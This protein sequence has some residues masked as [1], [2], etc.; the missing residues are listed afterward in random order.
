MNIGEALPR[1]AQH[2]PKKLALHDGT[3]SVSHLDLHLR[4]NRLS[5]YLLQHGVRRSDPV[6]FSCGNRTENFEIF[7]ALAKIGAIAV[8]FDYHWS[9]DECRM[10]FEFIAPVAVIL[11]GRSETYHLSDFIQERFL[12]SR[13]ITIDWPDADWSRPY[14]EALG[15]ATPEDPPVK[16]DGKDNLL[17]MITSGTTGFPKACLVNHETYVMRSLNNAIANSVTSDDRALLT[18]PLHFNAG[19]GSMTGVLYMGGTVFIQE[20]FSEEQF[21]AT[22][23]DEKISYTTLV[24]T[25]CTRLL[26]YPDLERYS[27]SFLRYI[28]VTGGQLSAKQSEEMINRVCSQ[29]Y[30]SYASTDC[31]HMT[32]LRPGERKHLG[33]DA[34]GRPIWCVL[35]RIMDEKGDEVKGGQVGEICVRSPLCIQGYYR[36]PEATNE[37]LSHGWCHTGDVGFLDTSDCLHISGRK[38]NM[39]KSGGISIFPEEIEAVLARHPKVAEAVIIGEKNAEWGESVKAFVV[40]K[41]GENC[42]YDELIRFCKESLAAYKA[43]KSMEF[44]TSLPKT[45]LGKIDRGRLSLLLKPTNA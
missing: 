12:P 39:I 25:V 13:T 14:E 34:V 36:N 31:G 24:P 5:N 29:V 19:R 15:S 32:A 18:L 22:V 4:T 7:F 1:N 6:V 42:E 10:M 37:F 8:P 11:E 23:Q 16:I 33:P 30:E 35:L 3:K 45:G 41:K 26:Q 38:K 20:K 28:W 44:V 21:L 40:L 17:I 2:Y 27:I 9:K 43:P